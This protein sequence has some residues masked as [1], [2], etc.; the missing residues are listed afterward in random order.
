MRH[1]PGRL[2]ATFFELILP[3][4]RAEF[5]LPVVALTH[6]SDL[7]G[8]AADRHHARNLLAIRTRGSSCWGYLEEVLG[9]G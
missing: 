9:P 2:S 7:L 6:Y 8:R 4:S 3:R 1:R 5:A